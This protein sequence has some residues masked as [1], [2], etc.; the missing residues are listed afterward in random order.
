MENDNEC[1][2]FV[3]KIW[4]LVV[5]K[6]VRAVRKYIHMV[7]RCRLKIFNTVMAVWVIPVRLS[8][9]G[10]LYNRPDPKLYYLYVAA[11][12]AE[13]NRSCLTST[14]P[15]YGATKGGAMLTTWWGTVFIHRGYV[16][17]YIRDEFAFVARCCCCLHSITTR[18]CI[19]ALSLCK[20]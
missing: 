13:S 5:G 20:R 4:K 9:W 2:D 19:I 1:D 8:R 11:S 17:I 3:M 10:I 18:T 15:T 7:I 12:I 6:R 16:M 14:R